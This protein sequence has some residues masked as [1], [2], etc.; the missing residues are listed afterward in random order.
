MPDVNYLS[1]RG[2]SKQFDSGGSAVSAI[3]GVSFD[4]ADTVMVPDIYPGRDIDKGEIHA[5]DLVNAINAHSDNC[6]YLPTFADIKAYLHENWQ[7]GDLVV[8]LGSGDV[9]KQQLVLLED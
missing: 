5:T 8:T 6:L 1:V 7:A 2:V 3:D 4:V 9:N